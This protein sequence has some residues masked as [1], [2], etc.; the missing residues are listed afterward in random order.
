MPGRVVTRAGVFH[1]PRRRLHLPILQGCACNLPAILVSSS[2][3]C[4]PHVASDYVFANQS[5]ALA[6]AET[7]AFGT[8]DL[9]EIATKMADMSK[10]VMRSSDVYD[11][12]LLL[13][14]RRL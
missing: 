6:F 5:E 13:G 7:Q 1:E 3:L 9:K 2:C 12:R 11:A 10:V 8:Q 4:G 14:V